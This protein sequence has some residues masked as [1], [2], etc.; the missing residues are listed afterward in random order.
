MKSRSQQ[1]R[2]KL[3][4]AL[5]R[6][7][8]RLTHVERLEDRRLLAGNLFTSGISYNAGEVMVQFVDGTTNAQKQ[9]IFDS[10][11]V[12]VERSFKSVNGAMVSTAAQDEAFIADQLEAMGAVS[13][14]GPNYF[15]YT[16]QTFPNDPLFDLQYGLHNTGQNPFA[17]TVDADIDAPEAWDKFQGSS[18]AVVAVLDSGID[19][20]HEALI[21]N[22]WVNPFE[23]QGNGIDDDG[24]GYIDDIHGADTQALDGD[25]MDNDGHGTHVSGILGA[26]GNDNVGTTGVAWHTQILAVR[27]GDAAFA[28]ADIL[29][30]YDYI[31]TMKGAGVN[32]VAANN[33]YGGNTPFDPMEFAGVSAVIDAGIVFVAS[34]GNSTQ[35]NDLLPS[36]P[37]NYDLP[38]LISVAATNQDDQL[39][40]FS[41]YGDITVDLAAPG[42]GILSTVPA[43][44]SLANPSTF[45]IG[46]DSFDGTSMAAPMVTGA[47]VLA[48][49][50]NPTLSVFEL[51]QLVKDSVDLIPELDGV[52]ETGGRLNVGRLLDM[53]PSGEIR[54]Q[55]FQD[56]NG[57]GSRDLGELPLGGWTVFTDLNNNGVRDTAEPIAISKFDGTYS[58]PH[59]RG[60]GSYTVVEELEAGFQYTV[61]TNG[62]RTVNIT[63]YDQIVSGVNFGNRQEALS[64]AGR[65]TQDDGNPNTVNQ[66]VPNI[67][68]YADLNLNGR[69]DINEPRDLTD[70]N[71][72]YSM[73][74]PGGGNYEIRVQLPPGWTQQQPLN[75]AGHS[76]SIDPG[77]A[78]T[79]LDFVLN[80]KMMSHGT[81]PVSYGDAPHGILQ[82]FQLGPLLIGEADA[83]SATSADADGVR[84][85]SALTEGA[86]IVTT[87]DVRTSGQTRGYLQAWID[88]D[89]N[90]AFDD[91]EQVITNA[92]LGEGTH[93]LPSFTVPAGVDTGTTWARFRYG[94]EHNLGPN[95]EAFAGEVEDMMV[96]VFG[97][98]P[99]AVN[100]SYPNIAQNSVFNDNTLDV[101]S[102]DVVSAAGGALTI[103]TF[104]TVSDASGS[105]RRS[106]LNP[107]ILQYQPQFGYFGADSFRYTIVDSTGATSQAVVTLFV[108]PNFDGPIAV[109]DMFVVE[110]N[111]VGSPIIS[112]NLEVQAN[113]LPSTDSGGAPLTTTLFRIVDAPDHGSAIVFNNGTADPTDDVVQYT[114]AQ[115][116]IG[117]DQLTYELIDSNGLT[118]QATVTLQVTPDENAVPLQTTLD[119]IVEYSIRF[120]DANG[121]LLSSVPENTPFFVDIYVKDL[122]TLADTTRPGVF[123]AYVDVIYNSQQLVVTGTPTR[124]GV[125]GVIED[126]PFVSELDGTTFVPGL[127]DELGG[128]ASTVGNQNPL[129]NGFDPLLVARIPVR[130]LAGTAGQNAI[131]STDPAN[132]LGVDL[133]DEI[134][135][136][137]GIH[138][139]LTFD[140]ASDVELNQ[141]RFDTQQITI[142]AGAAGEG[143]AHNPFTP[144]DV[145]GDRITSL[146]DLRQMVAYLNTQNG[147]GESVGATIR[148]RLMVDVNND[149]HASLND[150]RLVLNRLTSASQLPSGEGE[151]STMGAEGEGDPAMDTAAALVDVD[152]DEIDALLATD[153]SDASLSDSSTARR[154]ADQLLAELDAAFF[155]DIGDVWGDA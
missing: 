104:D 40:S 28:V 67:Y 58:L 63:S 137:S 122:R 16:E 120:T 133:T 3:A 69:A 147:E 145:N 19:W 136:I 126:S 8:N 108:T 153:D 38:G 152:A 151:A 14:A 55:I 84:F 127:V 82:G 132:L 129:P 135:E 73:P 76:I 119:D 99:V 143:E 68:V 29:A 6:R 45:P 66:P 86:A 146:A 91:Y 154:R 48:A 148:H 31:I 142:T 56:T 42:E 107:N 30:A 80:G 20:T 10:L 87:A 112:Y 140:P 77:V 41:N 35:D 98:E 74:L 44:Y 128:I 93:T 116:F 60:P 13:Y 139:T 1:Q 51:E 47:V 118:S 4:A 114:P 96:T 88:F 144:T 52:V 90:G 17:G 37:A 125:P 50:L 130:A 61:P 131:V 149:G 32:I 97:N 115:G 43:A 85:G 39:A 102:N 75:N 36:F 5:K 46:Y 141:M 81:A 18:D 54:G 27:M 22:L 9:A 49:G 105:V 71:G 2:R 89:R 72:N 150:L 117:T 109:D 21:P 83:A 134:N 78:T 103:L 62:K 106:P 15:R 23:I 123:A 100:D 111:F 70:S 33:S 121:Q 59:Y 12:T 113:D 25:P 92:R 94:W 124:L 57:N 24:N 7:R 101:L 34:A 53:V 65:V 138:D 64:V 95:D 26:A 11:G 155:N 79:G 110:S